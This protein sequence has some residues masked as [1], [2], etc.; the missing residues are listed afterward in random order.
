M[1]IAFWTKYFILSFNYPLPTHEWRKTEISM[2][3]EHMMD[4]AMT[5]I[6][7]K[8][9]HKENNIKSTQL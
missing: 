2:N 4:R 7:E 6:K 1:Q 8:K 5:Y 3:G 9:V